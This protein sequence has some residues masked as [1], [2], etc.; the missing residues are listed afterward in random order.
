MR[1]PIRTEVRE[2]APYVDEPVYDTHRPKPELVSPIALGI[3]DAYRLPTVKPIN[4]LVGHQ[5]TRFRWM[6]PDG[7]GGLIPKEK[8]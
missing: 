6:R 4:E 1:A 2:G 5:R 7:K 8:N 3:C